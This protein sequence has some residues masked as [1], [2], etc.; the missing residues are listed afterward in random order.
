[1]LL[2]KD[3]IHTVIPQREPFIMID[4]LL[5]VNT[6]IF[7]STFTIN[8][9]N[10]FVED[11]ILS[12]CAIIESVAQTCAAGFGYLV[13]SEDNDS[14]TGFIGAVSKLEVFGQVKVNDQINIRVEILNS[15]DKVRS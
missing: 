13:S 11:N 1:M 3:K 15:F 14:M 10:I 6:S 5:E 4:D 12:E 2:N 9:K 7:K 8:E